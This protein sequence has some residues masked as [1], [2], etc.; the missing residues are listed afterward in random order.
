M[1][2]DLR[3]QRFQFRIARKNG[4]FQHLF[5]RG[6]RS[7]DRNQYV[8]KSDDDQI[9]QDAADHDNSKVRIVAGV[10]PT[11]FHRSRQRPRVP[12][13]DLRPSQTE[14]QR[15]GQMGYEEPRDAGASQRS[16]AARIPSEQ[17]SERKQHRHRPEQ[18]DRFERGQATRNANQKNQ[19]ARQRHP[20]S[21][22]G[23]QVRLSRQNR[24]HE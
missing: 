17:R 19:Q 14:N 18:H 15:A 22:V 1:R 21:K 6:A 9:E 20:H 23:A 2:I 16:R 13:A 12:F 7:L 10:E 5:L 3:L 4:C 24:V 8:K 11:K